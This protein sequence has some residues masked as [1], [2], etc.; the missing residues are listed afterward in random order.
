[1]QLQF[2][3]ESHDIFSQG[4]ISVYLLL[5]ANTGSYYGI[6]TL[7]NPIVLE[8]F[9]GATTHAGR[10]G[11]TLVL[12]GVVGSIIAGVWLDRTKLFK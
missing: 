6:G 2:S 3:G 1:M 8:Y 7:L 5:G 10:I 12:S 9:P 4:A 11:L